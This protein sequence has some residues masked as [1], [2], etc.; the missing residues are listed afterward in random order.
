MAFGTLFTILPALCGFGNIP[1]I[2]FGSLFLQGVVLSFAFQSMA[3][4]CSLI[5]NQVVGIMLFLLLW[6]LNFAFCSLFIGIELAIWPFK[7][8]FYILPMAWSYPALLY[9]ALIDTT[10]S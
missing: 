1:W 9:S 7:L 4:S 10:Y 2:S 5:R 3:L 6:I 8:V